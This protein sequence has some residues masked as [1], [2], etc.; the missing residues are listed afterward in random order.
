MFDWILKVPPLTNVEEND[1]LSF[2]RNI[3]RNNKSQ[4]SDS[5]PLIFQY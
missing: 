5:V 4:V 1:Q 2:E 3:D